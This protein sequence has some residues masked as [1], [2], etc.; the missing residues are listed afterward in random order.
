MT[1]LKFGKKNF[2]VEI[3]DILNFTIMAVSAVSFIPLNRYSGAIDTAKT[4]SAVS[5]TP[6]K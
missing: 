4:I 5:M 1:P 3:P 6:R 2:V